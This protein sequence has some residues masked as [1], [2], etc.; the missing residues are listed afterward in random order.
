MTYQKLKERVVFRLVGAK[1]DAEILRNRPYIQFLDLFVVF[2]FLLDV[3][4]ESIATVQITNEHMQRWGVNAE[5]LY[6]AGLENTCKFFPAEFTSMQEL[7]EEMVG[8]VGE[9]RGEMYV[10]TNGMRQ[11]GATVLLYPNILD[12]IGEILQDDYYMLPSSVHEVI[13]LPKQQGIPKPIMDTMVQEINDT[14]LIPKETLSDHAY[15]FERQCG[16]MKIDFS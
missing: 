1:E 11:Y 13:I 8:N 12:M 14:Y 9:E 6:Q 15:L 3:S 10:L 4:Q 2:H 5:F 7:I 16:K